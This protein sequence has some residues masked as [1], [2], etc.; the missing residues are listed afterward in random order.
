MGSHESLQ[1][2]VLCTYKGSFHSIVVQ[3]YRPKRNQFDYVIANTLGKMAEKL[4]LP[5]D[6][7][8]ELGK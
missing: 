5:L 1:H 8:E 6:Q 7:P 3:F 4:V 2:L